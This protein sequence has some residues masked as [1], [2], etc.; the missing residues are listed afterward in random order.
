MLYSVLSVTRTQATDPQT[1]IHEFKRDL[2][3]GKTFNDK[4][5]N[6]K[7]IRFIAM[8]AARLKIEKHDMTVINHIQLRQKEGCISV[9]TMKSII[10]L[11]ILVGIFSVC[12]GETWDGQ[13][14]EAYG[15][16]GNKTWKDLHSSAPNLSTTLGSLAPYLNLTEVDE[17]LQPMLIDLETLYGQISSR[18][19][20]CFC[21][22]SSD[23]I[24]GDVLQCDSF[25]LF[26]FQ[27]T[28]GPYWLLLEQS[29]WP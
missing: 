3:P 28:L 21:T 19:R 13:N 29:Y 9:L 12:C 11:V 8:F 16:N 10:Q 24:Q 15:H 2:S 14:A 18:V 23:A 20:L 4:I 6:I 7:S 17:F 26:R 25:E 22:T 1:V 27:M 5:C